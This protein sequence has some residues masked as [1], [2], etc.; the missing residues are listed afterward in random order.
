MKVINGGN[1]FNEKAFHEVCEEL[2]KIQVVSVFIDCIGHGAN[3]REQEAYREA[4]VEK[5]QDRL[6]FDRIDGAHSY[7][8][9]Y[10]LRYFAVGGKNADT[11]S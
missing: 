1:F 2:E 6:K 8:Y 11:K 9:E 7:H 4:L 10:M 3:N 5:Y